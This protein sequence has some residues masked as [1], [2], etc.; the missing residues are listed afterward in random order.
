MNRGG[1]VGTALAISLLLHVLAFGALFLHRSS[2]KRQASAIYFVDI[3]DV[4]GMGQQAGRPGGARTAAV[5]RSPVKKASSLLFEAKQAAAPMSGQQATRQ[6]ATGSAT[7]RQAGEGA[8]L[9]PGGA[10][11]RGGQDVPGGFGDALAT[12]SG[13]GSGARVVDAAP[14]LAHYVEPRYPAIARRRRISG[15]VLVSVYVTASGQAQSPSIE[16]ASPEG[17][18]EKCVIQAVSQWSFRPARRN[19]QTIGARITVPVRFNLENP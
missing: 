11:G 9:A 7:H 17:L 8:V 15:E 19:G 4:S 14:A 5:T 6:A 18:F 10:P 13:D 2:W 1:F 12:G 16:R 3:S